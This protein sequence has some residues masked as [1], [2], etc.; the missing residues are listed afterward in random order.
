MT[1]LLKRK[2][3]SKVMTVESGRLSQDAP[4]AVNASDKAALVRRS[5]KK[6][7]RV[8]RL[9]DLL[10]AG[11]KRRR[12]SVDRTELSQRS[13]AKEAIVLAVRRGKLTGVGHHCSDCKRHANPIWRY[14]ESNRGTVFLCSPCK[15]AAFERSFG[16]ADIMPLTVSRKKH[17]DH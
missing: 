2:K 7:S 16:H 8:A 6:Q 15:I 5:V 1:E 12:A 10:D 14:S 3:R 9:L 4:L 17:K 11:K 13:L